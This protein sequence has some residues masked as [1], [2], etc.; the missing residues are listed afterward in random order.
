MTD[1]EKIY[2]LLELIEEKSSQVSAD[3]PIIVSSLRLGRSGLT[4]DD[5]RETLSLLSTIGS[6]SRCIELI[7]Y[8]DLMEFHEPTKDVV[9]LVKQLPNFYDILHKYHEYYLYEY[10]KKSAAKLY[11]RK[12]MG[13]SEAYYAELEQE[14]KQII[15]LK[16]ES[17][18]KTTGTLEVKPGMAISIPKAGKVKKS[19]GEKYFECKVM[20]KLFNSPTTLS[21]GV[22]FHSL[23]GIHKDKPL[24]ETDIK[25]VTNVRTAINK[26][27]SDKLGLKKL[28]I[29]NRNKAYV[30]HLYLLKD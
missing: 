8:P 30:N 13:L 25:K 24:K 6:P 9:Y 17:Y 5:V 22:S 2:K 28:I 16:P 7:E 21:N 4:R 18:N 27:L 26:K 14:Q 19:T 23:L 12:D 10:D 3:E 29:L 1:V 20:E 15:A 11:P